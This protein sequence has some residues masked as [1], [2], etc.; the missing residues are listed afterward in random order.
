MHDPIAIE[1]D[2]D[3]RWVVFRRTRRE[4]RGEFARDLMQ[5][6]PGF[7]LPDV[8]E[9]A[10]ATGL[11]VAKNSS[12]FLDAKTGC[13]DLAKYIDAMLS[14]FQAPEKPAPR[15]A[16]VVKQIR[17]QF[18]ADELP[19][20]SFAWLDL[21]VREDIAEAARENVD[22]WGADRLELEFAA[23]R[24]GRVAEAID[25]YRARSEAPGERRLAKSKRSRTGE[26]KRKGK[27]G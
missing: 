14:Y 26:R 7:T 20:W 12:L 25:A 10:L 15:L 19:L 4:Q 11:V 24:D 21:V 17:R 13:N 5:L 18:D 1:L 16:R 22:P 2:E 6:P 23:V 8:L 27:T 9:A 3:E